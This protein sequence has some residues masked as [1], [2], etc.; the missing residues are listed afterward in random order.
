MKNNIQYDHRTV[1]Y[2][3]DEEK[4]RIRQL[5]TDKRVKHI[6]YCDTPNC[7]APMSKYKYNKNQGLCDNCLS[8]I[9]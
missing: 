2:P 7:H 9:N 3:H 8:A 4:D 1:P 5:S 6:E